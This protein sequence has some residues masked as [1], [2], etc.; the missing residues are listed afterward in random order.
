M[1]Y[2]TQDSWI[3]REITQSPLALERVEQ[4]GEVA[5]RRGQLRLLDLD[6]VEADDRIDGDRARVGFLA[7][8][9]PVHLALGRHVDHRVVCDEGGTAEATALGEA[10]VGGVRQL[11]RG[12]RGQCRCR[13]GDPVLRVLALRDGH[14]AAPADPS[15]PADRVEVDSEPARRVEDRRAAC[16][17][18]APPGR[19]EHDERVA[20][21]APLRGAPGL[22]GGVAVRRALMRRRRSV[23]LRGRHDGLPWQA[24]RR[25]RAGRSR[26]RSAGRSP[27]SRRR[28]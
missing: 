3:D 11:G 4:P 20:H 26:R 2:R 21:C 8:D 25:R 12:R 14:L 24:P 23:V 10:A 19:R 1:L 28:P 15:T 9:L 22:V 13:A 5:P 17:P 27:S 6:V 18:A 7:H 16:E